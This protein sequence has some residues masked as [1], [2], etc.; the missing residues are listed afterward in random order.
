MN[1]VGLVIVEEGRISACSSP[2]RDQ[3]LDTSSSRISNDDPKRPMRYAGISHLVTR[4]NA[5]IYP[6]TPHLHLQDLTL[7]YRDNFT[8]LQRQRTLQKRL[9]ACQYNNKVA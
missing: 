1:R 8:R 2:K 4:Q 3:L 7:T 6:S 5:R 9:I